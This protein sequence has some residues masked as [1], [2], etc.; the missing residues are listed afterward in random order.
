[1]PLSEHEQRILAELEDSLTQQDPSFAK[2]VRETDVF[3]YSARR[4]R[5]GLAGFIIGLVILL[6]FFSSSV[7]LGF[8]GIVVMFVSAVVVERHA[9]KFGRA[10]WHDF[11]RSLRPDADATAD[12]Q[13]RRLRDYLR[14]R[15]SSQ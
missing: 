7:P 1:M 6:A 5:R 2:S 4:V 15:H 13:V 3:T 10:S 9:R 14:K 11:T 8:L 12:G